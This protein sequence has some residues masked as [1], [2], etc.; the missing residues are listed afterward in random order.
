MSRLL[1]VLLALIAATTFLLAVPAAATEG[2][3]P[4]TEGTTEPAEGGEGGTAV[5]EEGGKL[6]VSDNPHDQFGLILFGL[7]GVAVL[8]ALLNAGKQLRGERP[9]ADGSIRWR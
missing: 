6:T 9:A 1:V 5:E 8:F 4:A 7:G 2:E 3:A